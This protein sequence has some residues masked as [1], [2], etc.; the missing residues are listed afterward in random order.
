MT[1]NE[2]NLEDAIVRDPKRFI[3]D[4]QWRNGLPREVY[5]AVIERLRS[6]NVPAKIFN[7]FMEQE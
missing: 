3:S 4:E 5:C 1:D 7:A 2:M 6:S